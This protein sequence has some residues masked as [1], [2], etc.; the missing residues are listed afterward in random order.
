MLSLSGSA[1]A[2]I[3]AVA[4]GLLM[5]AVDRRRHKPELLLVPA[6]SV[7]PPEEREHVAAG[8]VVPLREER[9]P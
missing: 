1:N 3:A 2:A 6:D 8:D 5:E 4:A 7:M 9:H